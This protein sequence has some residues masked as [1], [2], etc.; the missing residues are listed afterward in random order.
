MGRIEPLKGIDLLINAA[1]Q[2]HA[3]S[4]PQLHDK[5]DFSVLIVGGDVHSRGEVSQ[6]RDLASGL[7]IGDHVCFL[8]AVDHEKLPLYYNAADVC[9]VP[10]YY[11]S[12][13]LVALEA[14][15]CGTPGTGLQ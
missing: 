15:A 4:V 14:M 2:L 9:V 7:G 10:S 5:S 3:E 12:F 6:L 8:G 1:A 11:E 13:G